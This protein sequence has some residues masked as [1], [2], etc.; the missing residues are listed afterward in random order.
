[1]DPAEMA[2]SRLH[3]FGGKADDS[4]LNGGIVVSIAAVT[5]IEETT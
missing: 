5:V 2:G 4:P 3:W 1:M